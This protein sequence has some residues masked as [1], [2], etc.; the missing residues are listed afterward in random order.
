MHHGAAPRQQLLDKA[1]ADEA[2]RTSDEVLQDLS[3][4]MNLRMVGEF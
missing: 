4:L 2:G 1:L 3:P